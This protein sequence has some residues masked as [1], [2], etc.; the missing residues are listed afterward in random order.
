[1]KRSALNRQSPMVRRKVKI[2]RQSSAAK[3]Y[4]DELEAMRPLVYVRANGWCE[5]CG[6]NPVQGVHH[7]KRRSQGGTN[8]M[9]NL[10]GLCSDCHDEIHKN[11]AWSYELGYLL[12][13]DDLEVTMESGG[14]HGDT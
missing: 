2:N 3:T 4:A 6:T 14:H 12:R 5:V 11:P 10:L 13:R 9:A 1:M 8:A 7:R